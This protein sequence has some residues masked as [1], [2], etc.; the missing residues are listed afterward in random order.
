[1]ADIFSPERRSALMSKVRHT[2]TSAELVVRLLLHRAGF[3]FRVNDSGL[4][5]RPDVV[6]AKCK[7]AIFVHG[8][9]WHGHSCNRG[10][11]PAT[12][13]LFWDAKLEANGRRD[14]RIRRQLHR[15]GWGVLVVWEC[16]VRNTVKIERRLHDFLK[17]RFA[18]LESL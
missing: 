2:G 1:M 10:R 16:E 15:K 6:V 18:R 8:C 3:R 5:G 17:T 14:R 11:R 9:F 12:N 4:P 7:A 13:T